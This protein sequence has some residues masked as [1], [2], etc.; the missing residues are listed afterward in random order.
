MKIRTRDSNAKPL[1][2]IPA[3]F[4]KVTGVSEIRIQ[5]LVPH[6]KMH[7]M[8]HLPLQIQSLKEGG[9]TVVWHYPAKFREFLKSD[10]RF[11]YP[12]QKNR[13]FAHHSENDQKNIFPAP[14]LLVKSPV[15][16]RIVDSRPEISG[17]VVTVSQIRLIA[18]LKICQRPLFR[19]PRFLR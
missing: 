3:I 6:P 19:V 4:S 5:I 14:R 15:T 9:I 8:A 17:K 10:S 18:R 12:T 7:L 13:I 1:D 2:L 16:V 11:L